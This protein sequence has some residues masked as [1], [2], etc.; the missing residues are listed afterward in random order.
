MLGH[1]AWLLIPRTRGWG[2]GSKPRDTS[3]LREGAV[4]A[5]YVTQRG[6]RSLEPFVI[7]PSDDL[8]DGR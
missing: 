2:G 8:C 1:V 4:S 5:G 6:Y 7:V 3:T